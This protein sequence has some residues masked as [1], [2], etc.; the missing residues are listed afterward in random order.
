MKSA[1]L[2][3]GDMRTVVEYRHMTTSWWPQRGRRCRTLD[4]LLSFKIVGEEI[5]AK[6]RRL[7]AGRATQAEFCELALR[8]KDQRDL[9][10]QITGRGNHRHVRRLVR[11]NRRLRQRLIELA[12]AAG[13][14]GHVL[15]FR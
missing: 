14:D 7:V 6:C 3:K 1:E 9:I 5:R 12:K 11:Q 15:I 2:G 8:I 13:R 4:V 10:R